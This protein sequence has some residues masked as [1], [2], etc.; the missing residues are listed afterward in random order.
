MRDEGTL[1]AVEEAAGHIDPAARGRHAEEFTGMLAGD[2]SE[3]R[4]AVAFDDEVFH[5]EGE[6]GEGSE[7]D[8][9]DPLDVVASLEDAAGRADD[10][11]V[12]GVV[13]RKGSGVSRSPVPLSPIEQG[14]DF[15]ARHDPPPDGART[16]KRGP[17]RL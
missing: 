2:A 12:R 15:L 1:E 13:V 5:G 16:P 4:D 6:I 3:Q 14:D 7:P 11:A 8:A 10:D 9:V 17:A